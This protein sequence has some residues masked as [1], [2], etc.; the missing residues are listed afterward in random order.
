MKNMIL[1]NPFRWA[2]PRTWP[3]MFYVWL[4]LVVAGQ[5]RPLWRWIQR[6]RAERWPTATG[7]IESLTLTESKR[8]FFS[9]T[10]RG[11]SPTFVVEISYSYSAAGNTATGT[12]KRDFDTDEEALEFQE[13]L[14]GKPVAV[15]YNP[16][17]PSN[18]A[19]SEASVELL[20]Q[21]R[22]PRTSTD[23][24]LSVQKS[25]LPPLVRQFLWVFIILAFVGLVASVWVHVG[26]VMGRRVV[27]EPFFWILH[28]GIFVVWF[29]A[30]FVAKQRVGNLNRK[31]FWKVLLRDLPDGVRYLLYGFLGYASGRPS[32]S[33]SGNR[34]S[35]L[36]GPTN[37]RKK[38]I[39]LGK[40]TRGRARKAI[41]P[42]PMSKRI[43]NKRKKLDCRMD[44]WSREPML[45]FPS[46]AAIISNVHEY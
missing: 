39:N 31:D 29:P 2:D 32:D 37:M 22:P 14:K 3:W 19:L 7:R 9:S 23:Y 17:K 33:H 1:A 24:P 41:G 43:E 21:T 35:I 15:H 13:D 8:S 46:S 16:N 25:S 20:L 11:S 4:A 5:L 12:Y 10:P 18:S 30:V 28:V 44:K 45:V 40:E 27:P 38:K 26:A 42:I 36:R 34:S 6:R